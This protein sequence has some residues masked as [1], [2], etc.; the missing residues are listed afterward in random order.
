MSEKKLSIADVERLLADPSDDARAEVAAKVATQFKDIELAPRERE[1]AHEI[2]GYLVHDVA[3]NVREALSRCLNDVP[4]APRNIVL[5]LARDIDAVA[6]PVLESSPVLT[7]EDLVGLV[8]YGSPAK[9]CA[10]AGRP[11]VAAPVSEALA[12]KGDRDA[13]L[14]LIANSGAV[15]NEEAATMLVER[16][17]DD[18][19]VA[20]PLVQ[21]NELPATL[22]ERLIAM[23]SEQMREY[24]IEHH[25]MDGRVAAT[26]EEQAR[27]RTTTDAIVRMNDDELRALVTQL[28]ENKRL[29][30]TLI[31]RTA[32]AG[33]MRF[34][35]AAFA[36]LTSV[37]QDR[38][39]RL[40][41]DV[42]ALGFR[43]VY[44]RAGMPEALYPAFR[45]VLDT[46]HAVRSSDGSLDLPLFRHHVLEG[47]R[48][49]YEQVEA[50]D[51]DMMI[52]KLGRLVAPVPA[53]T[54]R[55]QN[56]A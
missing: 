44:A 1:L 6:I 50:A 23:V 34:V 29:T 25:E 15:I 56:V 37:P 33:N 41:H 45:T 9:Q 27:E 24:L 5:Q 42:G 20:A 11:Q 26:L 16:Y 51:L 30:A 32:C 4:D 48:E 21:R 53:P 31:L 2:L 19:D 8:Y 3:V 39:W 18:A 46:F 7:D 10:I 55:D 35:E 22:V 40:I 38:I 12:L 54:I 47:L 43:A 14:R 49:V 36:E 13:V 17:A 52:D 28:I